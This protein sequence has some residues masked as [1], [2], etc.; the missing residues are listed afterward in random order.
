MPSVPLAGD[1]GKYDFHLTD[2]TETVHLNVI[3][4]PETGGKAF[5]PGVAPELAPQ[6]RDQVFSY[7]HTPPAVQVALAENSWHNGAGLIA[8]PAGSAAYS[9]SQGV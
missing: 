8:A 3:T 1:L 9:H 7:V 5:L 4:D 2:S 6:V